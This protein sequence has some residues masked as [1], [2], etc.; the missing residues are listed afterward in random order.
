MRSYRQYCSIA[1][2]LDMVGDRWSLLIVRELLLRGPSRFTDI[3]RAL[4]GIA[5]NLLTSRLKEM[6][7][8]GI[9]RREYAPRTCVRLYAL[10]D[11]GLALEPV[12]RTLGRWGL[13]HVDL[14]YPGE[15]SAAGGRVGSVA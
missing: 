11:D 1:R 10:T 4:P 13:Q 7:Q 14:R 5:S 3:K 6:E 15:M 2:G 9:V 8:S 12:L